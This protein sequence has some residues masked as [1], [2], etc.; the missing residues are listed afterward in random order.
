MARK[1]WKPPQEQLTDADE[2]RHRKELARKLEDIV[3]FGTEDDF[4]TAVK[5][6]KPEVGKDELRE[7][8]MQF[9]AAVREKRRLS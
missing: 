6:Y 5:A 2:L 9:R 3:S 1:R 4:V 7:L 8:I